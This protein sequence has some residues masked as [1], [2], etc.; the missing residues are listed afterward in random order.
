MESAILLPF[1]MAKRRATANPGG[2]P[3][4][5]LKPGEK[6]SDYLRLSVRVP[7]DDFVLLDAASAALAQPQW[8][9]V[10]DAVRAFVKNQSPAVQRQIAELQKTRGPVKLQRRTTKHA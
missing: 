9:I 2:R 7:P 4:T 3:P 8:K 6:S 10:V 5:G 1:R